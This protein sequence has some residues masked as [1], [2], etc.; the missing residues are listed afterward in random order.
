MHGGL[1]KRN[2]ASKMRKQNQPRPLGTKREFI[3]G[4]LIRTIGVVPG[5]KRNK[6]R[7]QK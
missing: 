6:E 3:A 2:L 1:K 4:A 7:E 5:Q